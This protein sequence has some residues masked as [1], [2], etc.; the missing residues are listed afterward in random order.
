M[1]KFSKALQIALS[2]HADQQDKG[3]QDYIKHCLAVYEKVKHHNDEELNCIAILHDALEDCKEEDRLKITNEM[4]ELSLRVYEAVILLTK[5]KR[6]S[7]D[8]YVE[9]I[10]CNRDAMIVKLADLEHNSDITRL[11]GLRTK[12][13]VRLE[14][15]RKMYTL[16]KRKFTITMERTYE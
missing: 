16:I 12:D 14:K 1:N 13:F 7:D 10:L 5:P 2:V 4:K 15:Y 6:E 9:W 8:E 11:K 3:G